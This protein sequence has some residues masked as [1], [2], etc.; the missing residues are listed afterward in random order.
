[1]CYQVARSQ[2]SCGIRQVSGICHTPEDFLRNFWAMS[3]DPEWHRRFTWAIFSHYHLYFDTCQKI[4]DYIHVNNLG[5]VVVSDEEINPN[6]GNRIKM[7]TW[8]VN[9][10]TLEEWIGK[11]K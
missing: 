6:S 9:W 5:T 10:A 1:M 3:D 4:V 7:Y 8:K 11:N 2:I